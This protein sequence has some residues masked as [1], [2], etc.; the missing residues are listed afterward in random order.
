MS[1][2]MATRQMPQAK[3]GW[4]WFA[5][6]MLLLAGVLNLLHGFVALDRKQF[7]TTHIAYNNLTFWGWAFLV[8]GAL[9]LFAG[10]AILRRRLSGYKFGVVLSGAAM[11]G[12]FL[13]A[14]SAPFE[15]I[16]GMSVNG[17][18]LYGLTV[19]AADDWV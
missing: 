11:I 9:E 14:F 6:I 8:W 18:V 5:A 3:S 10:A 4:V 1:Q 16:V 19:G 2:S 15:A 13:M 17:L 7:V 12:W